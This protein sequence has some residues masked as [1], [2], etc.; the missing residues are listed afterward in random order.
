MTLFA[1]ETADALYA[2][3]LAHPDA[4]LPR[5]VLADWL[6]ENGQEERAEFVRVQVELAA[7]EQETGV[8]DT[9]IAFCQ[10]EWQLWA[11]NCSTWFGNLYATHA[12]VGIRLDP[13]PRPTDRHILVRRGFPAEVRGPL[14]WLLGGECGVCGGRGYRFEQ[15]PAQRGTTRVM[16]LR[17]PAC[18]GTGRTP[19]HLAG[20]VRKW[21][22]EKVV[23]VGAEPD[24]IGDHPQCCWLEDRPGLAHAPALLPTPVFDALDSGEL[25]DGG[26]EWSERFGYTDRWRIFPT[27]DAALAALSDAALALAK[28]TPA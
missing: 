21:P 22:I 2:T 25:E 17:C 3:V 27:R 20:L 18:S 26:H 16:E 15:T 28:E 4:D 9:P 19:G 1:D 7:A 13:N 10:R 24:L 23:P 12:C 14:A 6:E 11:G 8:Y 5:L